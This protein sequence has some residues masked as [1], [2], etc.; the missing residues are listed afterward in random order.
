MQ[1]FIN[2]DQ[3]SCRSTFFILQTARIRS[4]WPLLPRSWLSASDRWQFYSCVPHTQYTNTSEITACFHR[5]AG[6]S[7][8][9]F[10][11]RQ[12]PTLPNSTVRE[13]LYNSSSSPQGD[14][15][16]H[17]QKCNQTTFSAVA[18]GWNSHPRQEDL[19]CIEAQFHTLYFYVLIYR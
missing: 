1:H 10:Q 18:E 4:A 11:R 3:F 12:S 14:P 19:P 6:L 7:W 2:S 17:Y 5:I 13:Q 8:Y 15:Q 9:L 16:T